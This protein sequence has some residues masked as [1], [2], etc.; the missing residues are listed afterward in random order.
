[1]NGTYSDA[2]LLYQDASI[3]RILNQILINKYRIHLADKGSH[4]GSDNF[5]PSDFNS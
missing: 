4:P 5:R 1:M 2:G 3:S